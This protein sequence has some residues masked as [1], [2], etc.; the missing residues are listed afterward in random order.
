MQDHVLPG[1]SQ[2]PAATAQGC[3]TSYTLKLLGHSQASRDSSSPLLQGRSLDA[4]P[5]AAAPR[6]SG[7]IAYPTFSPH[8]VSKYSHAVLQPHICEV[9]D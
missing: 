8:V 5:A 7:D 1:Q 4:L 6:A 3:G 2:S 9:A